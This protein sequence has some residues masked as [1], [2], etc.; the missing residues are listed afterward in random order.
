[1][2][3]RLTIFCG[4]LTVAVIGVLAM[5]DHT[6][7]GAGHDRNVTHVT[8]IPDHPASWPPIK[9]PTPPLRGSPPAPQPA[10]MSGRS[11]QSR[12]ATPLQTIGEVART[13]LNLPRIL[14]GK[15]RSDQEH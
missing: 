5:H 9:P 2:I 4:L 1:M 7:F 8:A 12:P 6:L 3:R 13:L 14:S 11:A 10:P 15:A